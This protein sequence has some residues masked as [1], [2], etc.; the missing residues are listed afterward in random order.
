MFKIVLIVPRLQVQLVEQISLLKEGELRHLWD[1]ELLLLRGSTR[2]FAWVDRCGTWWLRWV[3]GFFFHK[4]YNLAQFIVFGPLPLGRGAEAVFLP[5]LALELLAASLFGK[6]KGLNLIAKVE[7]LLQVVLY[8]FDIVLSLLVK[9][10]KDTIVI[11]LG[12]PSVRIAL[13]DL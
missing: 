5:S 2:S 6:T 9:N 4:S 11:F 8:V 10:L 12:I 3:L 7:G 1:D 13:G